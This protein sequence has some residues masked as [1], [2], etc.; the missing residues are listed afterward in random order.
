ML[1]KKCALS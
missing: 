1:W